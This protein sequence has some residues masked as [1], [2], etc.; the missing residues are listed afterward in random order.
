MEH[1]R[2]LLGVLCVWRITD[3]FPAENG[4]W[5]VIAGTRRAAGDGL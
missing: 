2:L 5:E 1:Y 4:P 3:L